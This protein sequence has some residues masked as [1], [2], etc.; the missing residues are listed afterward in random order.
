MSACAI[1]ILIGVGI[2]IT[3][4]LLTYLYL[5]HLSSGFYDKKPKI[6]TRPLEP[7]PRITDG[8]ITVR[9]LAA[10]L[11]ARERIQNSEAKPR[12]RR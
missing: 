11:A 12:D 2:A 3:P 6:T 5:C 9:I 1:C 7:G 8:D 10:V 4:P